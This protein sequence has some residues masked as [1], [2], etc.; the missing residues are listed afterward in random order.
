MIV[1]EICNNNVCNCIFC[2]VLGH[3]GTQGFRGTPFEKHWV[4]VFNR[5]KNVLG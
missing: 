5:V 4:E 2:S 1:R 3:G